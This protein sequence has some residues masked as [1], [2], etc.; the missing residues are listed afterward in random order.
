MAKYQDYLHRRFRNEF[1]LKSVNFILKN[2]TLT[3]DSKFY[4]YL[5]IK[6]TAMATIFAPSYSNLTIGYHKIYSIIHQ[7]YTLASK[8]FENSW[9]RYLDDCEILQKVNFIEP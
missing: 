3:F 1:A 8:H 7:S 6:G 4:F 2:Q 9:L 5:Q